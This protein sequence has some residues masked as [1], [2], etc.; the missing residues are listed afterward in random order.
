MNEMNEAMPLVSVI[1]P[2][3]N[4]KGM[5]AE[6]INCALDQDYSN[7]EIIVGDNCSTDGTF[8][9]LKNEF[10]GNE[11][12]KLFQ[13]EKNLGP[14]LNWIECLKRC[15][16]KY[17][18]I[19]W[20][21]DLMDES[22]IEKCVQVMESEPSVSFV[23]SSVVFFEKKEELKQNPA[24]SKQITRYRFNK[25]GVY[26]GQKFI[27]NSYIRSY[28][29]P[30]SPGCAMF[31]KE[32]VVIETDIENHIGY[33]HKKTGAGTDMFI[34]FKALEN[35]EKFAFIDE[36]LTFFREHEGSISCRDEKIFYGYW[37]SKI[38]FLENHKEYKRLGKYL[39][40]DIVAVSFQN[41]FFNRKAIKVLLDRFYCS[42]KYTYSVF[43]VIWWGILREIWMRK[44]YRIQGGNSEV[45]SSW[46]NRFLGK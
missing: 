31:R 35:G 13:N 45:F 34:F 29:M 6:A 33:E 30:V 22:Y 15:N 4:R 44:E 27:V 39:N 36:P 26:E 23:Y 32:K 5:S 41:D 28:A 12:V 8:E 10:S 40:S 24:D 14:V 2:V 21:D 7:I 38:T 17:I 43:N 3:Y 9:Y 18:K 16:G 20:S 25:T 19:L 46:R 37:S 11:K 1:I 42:S